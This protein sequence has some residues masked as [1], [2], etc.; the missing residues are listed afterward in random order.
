MIEQVKQIKMQS[1][2]PESLQKEMENKIKFVSKM[3]FGINSG[4]VI[5]GII[6]EEERMEETVISDTVNIASRLESLTKLYGAGILIS[7]NALDNID[8]KERFIVMAE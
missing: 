6:G 5:A 2:S 7:G 3:G 4:D 8:N 1:V